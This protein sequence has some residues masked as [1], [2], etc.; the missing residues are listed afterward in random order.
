[1]RFV[2]ILLLSL[3]IFNRFGDWL[4]RHGFGRLPGDIRLR[5]AGRELF[6]PL[7]SGVALFLVASAIAW[8]R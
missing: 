3:L 2:L 1:M 8:I 6:V 4:T 7:G 5:I